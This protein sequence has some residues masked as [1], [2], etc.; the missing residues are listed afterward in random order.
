MTLLLTR[1]PLHPLVW[2]PWLVY[3]NAGLRPRTDDNDRLL[4][5]WLILGLGFTVI[6]GRLIEYQA[7]AF[8]VPAAAIC[9]L[10][11]SRMP[12]RTG[13]ERAPAPRSVIAIALAT[14]TLISPVTEIAR[15]LRSRSRGEPR[16]EYWDRFV[17]RDGYSPGNDWRVAQLVGKIA[18]RDAR[19]DVWGQNT[20]LLFLSKRAPPTGFVAWIM[21][22]GAD[23]ERRRRYRERYLREFARHPPAIVVTAELGTDD[24]SLRHLERSFEVL[25]K[26][27]RADYSKCQRVGHLTVFQLRSMPQSAECSA[28]TRAPGG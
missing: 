27:I 9:A 11:V 2:I 4:L 8:L 26:R 21:L 28:A 25:V 5:G 24:A 10:G 3:G 7:F 23:S 12:A 22:A 20:A 13:A 17:Y 15:Y 19:V 16:A 18:P 1:V 14:A 6:Q